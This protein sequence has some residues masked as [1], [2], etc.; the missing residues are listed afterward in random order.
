M[1]I[2]GGSIVVGAGVVLVS[3]LST[4]NARAKGGGALNY[5]RCR[6]V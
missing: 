3:L 1:V 6:G 4:N 2:G 5:N